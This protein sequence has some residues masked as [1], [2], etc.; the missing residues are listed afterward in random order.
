MTSAS[1]ESVSPQYSAEV[2]ALMK[3]FPGPPYQAAQRAFLIARLKEFPG[4]DPEDSLEVWATELKRLRE[5]SSLSLKSGDSA[6]GLFSTT[7]TPQEGPPGRST[8]GPETSCGNIAPGFF[9]VRSLVISVAL[10]LLALPAGAG[11]RVFTCKEPLPQFTL[12]E[13]SNPSDAEVAK[14]CACIWSKLP[15]RGWER[16]VSAKIRKGE[17]P[18]WRGRGFAPRFGAALDACGG[19]RL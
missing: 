18:G 6:P 14:L 9:L 15:E 3:K 7:P 11:P 19:R 10:V 8:S 2:L 1:P 16:E 13:A 12:G 4:E 17:D 5:T